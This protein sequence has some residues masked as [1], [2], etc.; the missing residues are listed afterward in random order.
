VCQRGRQGI[1][2]D[3]SSIDFVEKEFGGGSWQEIANLKK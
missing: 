3:F 1:E 2:F